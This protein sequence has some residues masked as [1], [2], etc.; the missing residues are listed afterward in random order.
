M[1]IGCPKGTAQIAF[2]SGASEELPEYYF[3]GESRAPPYMVL[4]G[5]YWG[6]ISLFLNVYVYII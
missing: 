4:L 3:M 5:L 6:H 2:V 1:S